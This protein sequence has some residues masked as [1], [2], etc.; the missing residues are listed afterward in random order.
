MRFN[1]AAFRHLKPVATGAGFTMRTHL[2]WIATRQALRCQR[3][4]KKGSES[5]QFVF[6]LVVTTSAKNSRERVTAT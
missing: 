2:H 5:A 4:V 6:S 1:P 3:F